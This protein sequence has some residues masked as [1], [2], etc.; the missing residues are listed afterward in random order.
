MRQ[1]TASLCASLTASPTAS[2][3]DNHEI[4]EHPSY[5]NGI[6]LDVGTSETA[7]T[8]SCESVDIHSLD[9]GM[10]ATSETD[11]NDSETANNSDDEFAYFDDLLSK[12]S[13]TSAYTDDEIC[14]MRNRIH[15]I[16]KIIETARATGNHLPKKQYSKLVE[17]KKCLI[18][19]VYA[20]GNA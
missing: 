15:Q 17:Q 9:R 12:G 1:E 16:K 2:L 18:A 19:I 5:D 13:D 7:L 8:S 20:N 3:L 10:T 4:P 11:T 14:N 6:P